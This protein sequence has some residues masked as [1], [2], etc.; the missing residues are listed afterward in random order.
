MAVFE[1]TS[2]KATFMARAQRVASFR[3]GQDMVAGYQ[4]GVNSCIQHPLDFDQSGDK[5]KRL[6][7]YW[8]LVND[9]PPARSFATK[10]GE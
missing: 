3:E 8:L 4:L 9:P 7:F 6:G 1:G 5:V 2:S 10:S